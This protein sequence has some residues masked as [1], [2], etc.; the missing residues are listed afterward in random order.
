MT[1]PTSTPIREKELDTILRFAAIIN[2][3]LRIE[4]VL[5]YAMEWTEDFMGAEASTMYELDNEHQELFIRI[6]RGEKSEP[7]KSIVLKVG[8]GVAGRVVQTGT[9]MII[10]DVTK[11][12][13]FSSVHDERTGFKT[14]SMICVPLTV[15]GT[16]IGAL[17]VL[18]KRSGEPFSSSDLEL[19]SVI[20]SQVA[21]AMDNAT[22]YQRLEN[23][24]RLTSEELKRTQQRLIRNERLV[25]VGHLVQGVAHEIRNP[26][27]T[28]GG[29][30][31]RIKR[32]LDGGSGLMPYVDIIM[33]EAERLE[34]VVKSVKEFADVLSAHLRVGELAPVL[35]EA[36]EGAAARAGTQ[37]VHMSVDIPAG[38]PP[39]EIDPVQI[40][41]ALDN[42]IENALEAMPGGG[43]LTLRARNENSSVLI[44]VE[45]TGCGIDA[46]DIDS[47]YDPFFSSKTRG[48][49]LGLTMV[50][51]IIMNHDG[52]ITIHSTQGIG[53]S[54]S[55][56]LP[57]GNSRLSLALGGMPGPADHP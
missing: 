43:T 22:L 46:A 5:N 12:A 7:V 28:I 17:Q 45:D 18:N 3:S 36:A 50:H 33:E 23:K 6:A 29:F 2:S 41:I 4:D 31:S 25:A 14:R 32:Q 40:R 55:I 8:E 47:V 38:L 27:T 13:A 1:E 52:E 44:T 56:A 16:S 35:A 24:F 57:T 39:V 30:A 9:P 48:A 20:S 19:L 54:V 49:G 11:E 26:I 15:R 10:Q 53:T 37:G 34:Q 21:V 42:V 51:Q